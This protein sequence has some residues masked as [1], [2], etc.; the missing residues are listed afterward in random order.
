MKKTLIM[1]FNRSDG[2]TSELVIA[3]PREDIAPEEIRAV[4]N[5]IVTT[6]FFIVNGAQLVSLKTAFIRTVDDAAIV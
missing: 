4:V 2:R 1:Q 3:D 5:K 6:K